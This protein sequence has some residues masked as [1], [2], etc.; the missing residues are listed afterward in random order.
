MGDRIQV[1][2]V[3]WGMGSKRSGV[4][5]KKGFVKKGRKVTGHSNMAW[6]FGR[7]YAFSVFLEHNELLLFRYI[8]TSQY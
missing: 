5:F 8:S 7:G 4:I 3:G 2:I 6:S 1:D